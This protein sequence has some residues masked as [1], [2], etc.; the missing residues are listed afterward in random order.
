MRRLAFI[1]LLML[2]HSAVMA[3][4]ESQ[5][6][7]YEAEVMPQFPG[8]IDSLFRYL[9]LNLQYPQTSRDLGEQGISVVEFGVNKDG[10]VGDVKVI[11]GISEDLDAESI[12]AVLAMPAWTPGKTDNKTI[13]VYMRLPIMYSL[14]DGKTRK[15]I[16]KESRERKKRL[17][18][19][20][21]NP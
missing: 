11:R 13:T 5:P 12:R 15:E 9:R 16:K 10:S 3:Q 4:T 6:R 18:E 21:S 1:L 14:T 8:G 7:N 20:E 2:L 19:V 17:K